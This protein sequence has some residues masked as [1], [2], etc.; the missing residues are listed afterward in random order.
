MVGLHVRRHEVAEASHQE[1]RIADPLRVLP[2]PVFGGSPITAS[3]TCV[4]PRDQALR[5][6]A[7]HQAT[8]ITTRMARWDGIAVGTG[9]K[10]HAARITDAFAPPATIAVD[11]AI[12][13]VFRILCAD[14]AAE[15]HDPADAIRA[16]ADVPAKYQADLRDITAHLS[17]YFSLPPVERY[18][19]LRQLLPV[20]ERIQRQLVVAPTPVSRD[21]KKVRAALLHDVRHA[22][23]KHHVQT[24]LPGSLARVVG[25]LLRF[26]EECRLGEPFKKSSKEAAFHNRL[27][28][29]TRGSIGITRSEEKTGRGKLDLMLDDTPV[30]LK[31]R[32][33]GRHPEKAITRHIPQAAA[34]ASR[35]GVSVG[36]L[37]VLDKTDRRSAVGHD[38]PMSHQARVFVVPSRRSIAGPGHTIVVAIA[39]EAFPPNPSSLSGFAPS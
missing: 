8:W 3:I 1:V 20:L 33:L 26:N 31:A 11:D 18:I 21:A 4:F 23:E 17:L 12:A 37:A 27:A 25:E 34:Y 19:R 35:R 9:L 36:V 29:F 38:P 5:E 2:S 16:L 7:A 32:C 24:P 15:F 30:E 22:T 28:T 39:I 10:R 6:V 14:S 13:E